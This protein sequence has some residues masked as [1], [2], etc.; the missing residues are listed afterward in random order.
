MTSWQ[1]A[2]PHLQGQALPIPDDGIVLSSA[3]SGRVGKRWRALLDHV[4]RDGKDRLLRGRNYARRGRVRA[5]AIDP[6]VASAGVV[7]VDEYRPTVRVRAFERAEW[8]AVFEALATDLRTIAALLEGELSEELVDLL[9]RAGVRL[10]PGPDEVTHDCDCGDYVMPC[11]HAVAIHQILG[12]ALDGDP[13]LLFALRGRTRDHLLATLRGR[14]GDEVPMAHRV[15]LPEACPDG[16]WLAAPVPLPEFG[17]TMD[18]P[19]T[20]GAGMLA[21]GPP[22]GEHDL[23]ATLRPLYAAGASRAREVAEAVPER[24]HRRPG[25]GATPPGPWGLGIELDPARPALD[26]VTEEISLSPD[27]QAALAAAA[28][29]TS[30]EGN[31]ATSLHPAAGD[32]VG[33]T[34][35]ANSAA[36][37]VARGAPEPA[38]EA[39]PL[40]DRGIVRPALLTERLVD[41]LAGYAWTTSD[42]LAEDLG[43][44]VSAVRRELV[45]LEHLGLVVR[46]R[47]GREV[48][49]RLG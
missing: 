31:L 22:P 41:T 30:A 9:E 11:T 4:G 8:A 29:R 49:W 13:F 39:D 34:S 43:V 27:L 6:G 16:D 35:G 26:G 14:W 19:V 2:H 45:E 38:S 37:T 33:D 44:T 21:L 20:D 15:A 1:Q 18:E 17:A 42:R 48:R 3:P 24:A 36:T 47:E 32:A 23:V 5:L 40:A 46:E 12:D 25:A 7:C 10:V 28:S